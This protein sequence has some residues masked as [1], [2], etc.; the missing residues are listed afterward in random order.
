MKKRIEIAFAVDCLNDFA[1]R[2]AGAAALASTGSARRRASVTGSRPGRPTRA[3]AR[4]STFRSTVI[5][6]IRVSP[7]G[8]LKQ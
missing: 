2:A 7:S 8:S 5:R 3:A 6:R 1:G 4:L